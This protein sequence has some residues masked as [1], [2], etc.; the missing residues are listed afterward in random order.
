MAESRDAAAA[1]GV[2]G[3]PAIREVRPESGTHAGIGSGGIRRV[4]FRAEIDTSPPFGSVKEA[5]T[6]FGGSGPWIP[7]FNNIEDFDLK[8]VEEQAAELEKDLIVKELETLDV[9]EELGATKRIVEDLKQQLQKEA[10]KCLATRDVNSY[11]EAGTP[12]IKEKDEDNCGNIVNDEE[13][14]MQIPSPCSMSSSPDM[15]LMELKKAKLNLGKTINELGVIQSSIE[16]LN[17]KMKKEK[18]FLER[19]REKLASKFAAESAQERVQEQTRL[20][21]PAPHVEFTFGNPANNF[22]SDSGQCNGMAET[23]RPEPSKPLSV[24]EEY[25]F[26]VK[27]A[28]IR[29]LAAKKMEEAARAAEAI[30]LAEIK[31]LSNAQRSLGFVLPEPEKVTFAFGERSPLNPKAQIPKESTLKKVIDSKFQIDETKISKLTIL[32]KLE[33]AAEEVLHSK[34]VLT[35]ALNRIETA[36]R[37]QH[38]AKEALRRWIPEDDMKEYSTINCNKF[39]QTGIYQDSLQDVTRS[40][41]ANNDPKPALRPT[42]SMRDVLSRKQ[43]P[44]GYATRKEMEEHTER[45]KVALSQMLQALRE[46]LTL[47]PKTEKDGNNQKPYVAQRKKFGFIQ[48]SLPLAKP[49]KKRG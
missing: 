29:W 8:K 37:K 16:S 23:R 10:M 43:V 25:G 3:T 12:V 32:K 14:V 13:Q 27:T 6:R 31:A 11:E 5:V 1:D 34:Q 7:F 36:N 39:N 15:I 19:T 21:P 46:D 18:N 33:E 45:Q 41:T 2:P 28:E 4:N 49:N 30:A 35:D 26:S 40:T 17:K 42:I 22:N 24:Y 20:N 44:E 47:P 38:A 9:L 48:I